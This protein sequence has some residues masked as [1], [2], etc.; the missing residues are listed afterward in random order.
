VAFYSTSSN[1]VAGDTNA[2]QDVFRKDLQTGETVR[3][4][5]DSSG[6]EGNNNSS[7]VSLNSDGRYV[8]FQSNATNLVAGDSNGRTDVF[9]KD[10]QTD[11]T[12]RVSTDSSGLEV[13]EDSYSPGI[14]SDGRYVVFS[15]DA[16]NLVAGD[17]NGRTDIFRK[18]LQTNETIRVSTDSSGLQ[19]NDD[20]TYPSLSPDGRY[21]AFQSDATN[22]VAGDTNGRTDV[23]R[24]DIQTGETI[25]VSTDSSGNQAGSNSSSPAIN[26][27]GRYVAFKSLASFSP[28]DTNQYY[29]DVYRKDIVTGQV[30][31]CSSN[32]EGN[33]GPSTS[34]TASI[35]SD[36]RYVSLYSMSTLVPGA[37]NAYGNIY[38]KDLAT[39]KILCCTHT[40]S[41]D[42]IYGPVLGDNDISADGKYVFMVT[43]VDGLVPE[44]DNGYN[45][46]F[47]KLPLD[48]A[49]FI[50]K[51]SP[52][53]GNL[54]TEVTLSGGHF[55]AT[56]GSSYVSFG[57]AKVTQYLSWSNTE[58]HCRVPAGAYGKTGVTVTT[59]VETSNAISF[60]VTPRI[61][62]IDP[63]AAQIGD[64]I[65]LTGAGFEPNKGDG[66][67]TV[68]RERV[69]EYILWSNTV[70]KVRIPRG[71]SGE[72]SVQVT[73]A[74]RYG[75][76]PFPFEVL[77]YVVS[78]AEGYTGNGFQEYLCLGNPNDFPAQVEIWYLFPDSTYLD[79]TVEIPAASRVTVD[80]NDFINPYFEQGS[81][82]SVLVF[83]DLEIVVERPM[84]FSY[85]NRWTGG[86][87][88]VGSPYISKL[89]FFA[90][91][92]TGPGFDEYICVLNPNGSPAN[93]TFH[94]Q[95][96]EAGEIDKTE[97]VPAASRRTFKVNELLGMNYQCSLVL[98]SDQYVVAERPMY[99]D[100]TGLG[101]HHWEG[102]HCVMGQ[103]FLNREYYFAEGTTRSG[104]E[105][106]LTIQNPYPEPI[107]VIA[108]YQLGEG[109]GDPV[110]KSY[111][112]PSER[113][114]TVNVYEEVGAEKDVSVKLASEASFLAERPMYFRYG[115]YGASW[116]DGH[117]VIGASTLSS[118]WFFAEG[119][120]GDGFH[121][122]ICLQNPG[123]EDA[124]VEVDYLGSSGSVAVKQVIVPA[125]SRKTLRVN[126]EAG[127]GLELS[128]SL[129]VIS[130]PPVMAERP[131]Y[132][133]FRGWDGGH[134]VVG[135]YP[136]SG[137][138][139][140]AYESA[141]CE[142]NL[143]LRNHALNRGEKRQK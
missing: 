48:E 59:P 19:V 52:S 117:C 71:V 28:G 113:R 18:D 5:T 54:T 16:N 88:V 64:E 70:I 32:A 107:T 60:Q 140:S 137:S 55:G 69:S 26:A 75:S 132:F 138:T 27:D 61:T 17:T 116:E 109:Q 77:S 51:I 6:L 68:G 96:Q 122:W 33:A 37:G 80:V 87:D 101:N 8:A 72:T 103:P 63:D 35:S 127:N 14:S 23:F 81:E 73:S 57:A 100:Y 31:L 91:G 67:V 53:Q 74:S 93:L 104:F 43:S 36:G 44:D 98:E 11:E 141:A 92:Y 9:R 78:F 10:L 121:E 125:K 12:I 76:N 110:I 139:S 89:W 114:Y 86:H 45:D 118:T 79:D 20:S 112:I 99:F 38:R 115:G 56:R 42:S 34:N 94:F 39:G 13:N 131:I 30:L 106:W 120:T 84:Y 143:L 128:C 90:E 62:S 2:K 124:V 65:T 97:S 83:S 142:Q 1:L 7:L 21:V 130:G 3:C 4:S 133:I 135:Y 111:V 40:V 29:Y 123:E 105:E 41:G 24:K 58:I 136:E 66:Y 22:L 119:C 95:T 49:P 102:G 50:S 46:V 129:R 47:R 126:D 85:Q 25:R 108:T 15:S 82:V 134:D